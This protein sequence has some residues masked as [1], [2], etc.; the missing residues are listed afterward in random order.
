[1]S[2]FL[3]ISLGMVLLGISVVPAAS[4]QMLEDPAAATVTP[5]VPTISPDS[6]VTLARKQVGRRYVFGGARPEIGFDCSGLLQY[7][8]RAF[9]VDLPRNSAAQARIGV[10]VARDIS[11]LRVGDLLTFGYRG[12]VSHIGIYT[13]N[14]KFVHASTGSRRVV[15]SLLDRKPSRRVK[16]WIGARRLRVATTVTK[17]E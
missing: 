2:A 16:P 7:V 13:G 15:E 12:K 11:K 17:A 9:K 3:P 14:G 6:V 10:P 5:A 8:W 1:M 4:A